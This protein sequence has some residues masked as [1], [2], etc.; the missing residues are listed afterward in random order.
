MVLTNFCWL[1]LLRVVLREV[2]QS[3]ALSILRVTEVIKDFLNKIL[4]TSKN[5]FLLQ[6][7]PIFVVF[8]T[9]IS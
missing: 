3:Y 1:G 7:L 9:L 5:T 6:T 8:L 4:V 2:H